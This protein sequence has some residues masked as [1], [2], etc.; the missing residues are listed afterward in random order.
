M[1]KATVS[2]DEIT[3][4]HSVRPDVGR[5]YLTFDITGWPDVSKVCKKV[6]LFEG[7]KF[8]FGCWNSDRMECTFVRG[9]GQTDPAVAKIVRR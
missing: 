3:V 1:S 5:E 6:L 2:P 8:T 4:R 7:R 9:I